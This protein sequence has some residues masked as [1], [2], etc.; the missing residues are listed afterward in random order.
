MTYE[1][2]RATSIVLLDLRYKHISEYHHQFWELF[3]QEF[4]NNLTAHHTEPYTFHD[5]T[6]DETLLDEL[7]AKRINEVFFL[8]RSGY[9]N[10]TT[11]DL[12]LKYLRFH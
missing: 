2:I 3:G 10:D 11:L 4:A 8:H 9:I 12:A 5:L 1:F 6:E 7:R